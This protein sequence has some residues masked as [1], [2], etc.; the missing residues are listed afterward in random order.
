MRF[1]LLSSNE[2]GV[3][4]GWAR[5]RGAWMSLFLW[6]VV[7]GVFYIFDQSECLHYFVCSKCF[8]FVS[9]VKWMVKLVLAQLLEQRPGCSNITNF[10]LYKANSIVFYRWTFNELRAFN[11]SFLE[12]YFHPQKFYAKKWNHW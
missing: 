12:P 6:W 11:Y 8:S 5:E 7:C 10:Y 9:K 4:D 2:L 3:A 1:F